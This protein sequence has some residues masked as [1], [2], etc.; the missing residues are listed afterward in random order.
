VSVTGIVLAGG[1]SSRFGSDK[2]AAVVDG[3]PLLHL[4]LEA[5]AAVADR[6]I[7]VLAP[8]GPIPD[9]PAGLRG[10]ILVT[11]DAAP[12]AG[13]LAGLA[14]GLGAASAAGADPAEIAIVV[15]GDMPSLRPDVLR[16]LARRLE[17]DPALD[18]CT[19]DAEGPAPLPMAV[20]RRSGE[21]AEALL[22]AG[23]R[24]L[25]ALTD[26]VRSTSVSAGDWREL[27]PG[28]G[29]LLDIDTPEDLPGG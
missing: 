19:L 16:L 20:R 15:G 7:L 28:G 2:L 10:R 9:L 1:A 3:R 5:V 17:A 29:T 14:T 25:L 21:A 12:H 27:D 22:A 8:E 24:S 4:S 6:V 11:R 18:A 13:P 23:R 26:A